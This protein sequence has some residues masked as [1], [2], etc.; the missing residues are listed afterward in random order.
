M[1]M[2]PALTGQALSVLLFVAIMGFLLTGYIVAFT[3]GGLAIL[4]AAAGIWAGA[5][6][7]TL[8]AG[9]PTRFWGVVTNPV[10]IAV[11]LFVFMGVVLER[12]GIAE[13]LTWM[14]QVIDRNVAE[15]LLTPPLPQTAAAQTGP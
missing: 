9:L 13:T 6:D 12:S 15:G 1:L 4:F 5:F 10:L 8:L 3:L 11:P 2:D 7:P 14:V